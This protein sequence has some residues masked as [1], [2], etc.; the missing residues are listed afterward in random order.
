MS[1]NSWKLKKA[2]GFES[3]INAD[4]HFR[5]Y[6]SNITISP[7]NQGKTFSSKSYSFRSFA[8]FQQVSIQLSSTTLLTQKGHA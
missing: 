4:L 7:S 5:K 1:F 6:T 2:T 8:V 3:A